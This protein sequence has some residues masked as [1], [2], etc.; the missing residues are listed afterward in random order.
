M[1]SGKTQY[2]GLPQY[3][4]NDHPDWLDEINAA[5]ATIDTLIHNLY[6]NQN[7]TTVKEGNTN[8]TEQSE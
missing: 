2:Y 6:V 5:F 7:A 1:C 3:E 8:G 4:L